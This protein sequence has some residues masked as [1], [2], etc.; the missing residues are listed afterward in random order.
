VNEEIDY[1]EFSQDV[2]FVNFLK[3]MLTKDQE[4]RATISDLLEDPYLTKCCEEPIDLF[5]VD[6]HSSTSFSLSSGSDKKMSVV[7][8]VDEISNQTNP[9]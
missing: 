1:S 3:R 2:P 4:T 5:D 9:E 7:D 6:Q 8:S